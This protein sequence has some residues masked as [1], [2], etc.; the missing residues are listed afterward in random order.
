V[1]TGA[2]RPG[3]VERDQHAQGNEQRQPRRH[4]KRQRG[5]ASRQ[6]E[7]AGLKEGCDADR[8]RAEN[9]R[10]DHQGEPGELGLEARQIAG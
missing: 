9:S 7:P 5:D 2:H 6:P 8:R 3:R 10:T 4:G 1:A